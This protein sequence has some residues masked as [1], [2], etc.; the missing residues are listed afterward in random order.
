MDL[1]P[2]DPSLYSL[3]FIIFIKV[4]RIDVLI[5][6]IEVYFPKVEIFMN[7]GS[8]WPFVKFYSNLMFSISGYSLL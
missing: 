1:L 4:S 7:S 5:K 8:M 6:E 3:V 2:L